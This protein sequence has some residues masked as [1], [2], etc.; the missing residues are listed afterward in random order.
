MDFPFVDFEGDPFQNFFA[1]DPG[2]EV[3]DGEEHV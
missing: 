2:V 3:V 1:V